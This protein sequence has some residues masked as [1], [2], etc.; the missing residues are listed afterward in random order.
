M[1]T[2][3]EVIRDLLPLYTDAAGSQKSRE[4]VEEHLEECPDCRALLDELRETELEKSLRSER[5]NVVQ[6]AARWF[7]RRTAAVG[8]A[9]SGAFMLP[10]LVLLIINLRIGLT[11][12]WVY[13][14]LAA[15]LVP[16]SL[17]VVPIIMPEDK[18][19]WT[20]C[21]FCASLILLLAVTCLY[22]RGD[23]FWIAASAVLFGLSVIF[24]PFLIRARPLRALLGSSN[25]LLV[26]LGV[27]GALFM[28]ML[29]VIQLHQSFKNGGFLSM[30]GMLA[31][32]G[33]VVYEI[34]KKR[35]R[36]G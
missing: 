4:L 12:S 14:V 34:V 16:A 21:A 32:V 2:D 26:V 6:N 9:V 31:L 24:L 8:S 28:N 22:S 33:L 30:L 36:A 1:K 25:R 11:V 10:I 35:N 15:L 18:A 20:F 19:F 29:N 23:W 17:I 7:K 5:D 3:C 27:D 13:V